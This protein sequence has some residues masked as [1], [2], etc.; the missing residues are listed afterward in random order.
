MAPT[1]PVP[2]IPAI[3][4]ALEYDECGDLVRAVGAGVEVQFQRDA[5]VP[6]SKARIAPRSLSVDFA[7]KDPIRGVRNPAQ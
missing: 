3:T 6:A 1:A 5:H 4:E 7:P 2:N